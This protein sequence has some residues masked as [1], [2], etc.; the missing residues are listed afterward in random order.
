MDHILC[1]VS[2]Q[3]PEL[4]AYLEKRF[5]DTMVTVM[6]DRRLRRR[7]REQRVAGPEP[8]VPERRRR[9]EVDA[10]LERRSLTI[11]RVETST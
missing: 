9:P 10:E 6:L 7:R 1:I 3:H 2:R 4:F 5:A 11:V 8:R